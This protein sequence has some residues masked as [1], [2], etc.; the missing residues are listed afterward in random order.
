MKLKG[1]S[2]WLKAE[3]EILRNPLATTL[4]NLQSSGLNPA[5]SLADK[6]AKEEADKKAKAEAAKPAKAPRRKKGEEE[7]GAS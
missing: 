5:I 6:K 7:G 3:M 2:K 4:L 1:A